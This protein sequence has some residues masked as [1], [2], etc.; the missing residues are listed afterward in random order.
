MRMVVGLGNPGRKYAG[1]RHNAGFLVVERLAQRWGIDPE[2]KQLGAL[3]GTGRVREVPTLLV[4]PQG[5]MN[6]SGQPS[7]ALMDFY[8]VQ[9]SD[10]LVVHDEVDLPFGAVRVK[11]G[12][13][14]GGH[15]GLRDLHKHL[16]SP[17][18][19][20]VRVGV[21]RP[22]EGWET[23]DYVLGAWTTSE[24]SE[25]PS[26]IDT[27]CD[28]VET[29]LTAGLIAAMNQFNARDKTPAP[30]KPAAPGGGP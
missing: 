25:L 23:A 26:V 10:V 2:R 19:G 12:G 6:L 24:S 14:H 3:V 27:A 11:S 22:P 29:T 7:R 30:T 16:G 17:E 1:T 20:R 4:R 5:F 8:K 21:G 15:N 18:Y 9:L 28:A 13:G